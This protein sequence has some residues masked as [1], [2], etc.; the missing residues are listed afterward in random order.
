MHIEYGCTYYNLCGLPR[1]TKMLLVG[2]NP[3]VVTSSYSCSHCGERN[4]NAILSVYRGISFGSMDESSSNSRAYKTMEP[5]T[6]YS[7]ALI[8]ILVG[9][10]DAVDM[11]LS[12]EHF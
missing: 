12:N 9:I 1:G 10:S 6:E 11:P 3:L 7:C 8:R 2:R 4:R 5:H